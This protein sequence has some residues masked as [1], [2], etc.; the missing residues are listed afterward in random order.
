MS[1]ASPSLP[2]DG[3]QRRLSLLRHAKSSWDS[4]AFDDHERPL[5]GRGQAAGRLLAAYFANRHAP[6]LVLCSDALRARQTY[7]LIAAGLPGRPRVLF[8]AALYLASCDRLLARIE[9]VS[10]ETRDFLVIGHNP[11]LHELA[12]ILAEIGPPRLIGAIRQAFPTGAV[13]GYV[14]NG[15]WHELHSIASTV[16]EFVTPALLSRREVDA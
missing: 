10:D 3:A 8:E 12:A 13:A 2:D 11:G 4:S 16:V 5:D 14:F 7:A 9:A 6:D 1:T 15:G